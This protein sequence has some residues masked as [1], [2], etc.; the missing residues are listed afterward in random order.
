MPFVDSQRCVVILF[1][2]FFLVFFFLIISFLLSSSCCHR[3]FS[4]LKEKAFSLSCCC[5]HGKVISSLL[6]SKYYLICVCLLKKPGWKRLSLSVCFV[7]LFSNSNDWWHFWICFFFVFFFF[8]FMQWAGTRRW[9][10]IRQFTPR[11]SN[12]LTV[13]PIRL[14]TRQLTG[15]CISNY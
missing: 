5:C 9:A 13:H 7:F 1:L 8:C 6:G 14:C 12:T 15:K 2:L 11:T 3:C 4:T 10:A